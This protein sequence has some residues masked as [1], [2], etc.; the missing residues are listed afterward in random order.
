MGDRTD[1]TNAGRQQWCHLDGQPSE[2]D[3]KISGGL[4]DLPGA[5]SQFSVFNQDLDIAMPF[6]PGYMFDRDINRS[7]EFDLHI[8]PF[9]SP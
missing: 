2:H 7:F 1:P 6:H 4:N 8:E 5:F 9:R 3:L